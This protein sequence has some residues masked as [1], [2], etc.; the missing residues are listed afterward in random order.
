MCERLPA[1]DQVRQLVA[2]LRLVQ[3]DLGA[4]GLE[5]GQKVR[6]AGVF[7]GVSELRDDDRGK[8]AENDHHDQDFDQRESPVGSAHHGAPAS[9]LLQGFIDQLVDVDRTIALVAI[10]EAIAAGA[11]AK[12][13]EKA[14]K[15]LAKGDAERHGEKCYKSFDFYK[16][17][18]K[19]VVR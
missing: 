1:T 14:R 10:N 16:S 19:L 9:K 17:A 12:T 6:L 11:P 2:V 3:L 15:E 18:W 7:T 5:L 8:D 4:D 13:I